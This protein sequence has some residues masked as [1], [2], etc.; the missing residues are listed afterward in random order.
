[1]TTSSEKRA[2]QQR[3]VRT[4][5]PYQ[6]ALW[7]NRDV[8]R[9]KTYMEGFEANGYRLLT[10][11]DKRALWRGES[12]AIDTEQA[13]AFKWMFDQI[14]RWAAGQVTPAEQAELAGEIPG[15]FGEDAIKDFIDPFGMLVPMEGEPF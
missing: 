7:R 9:F 12:I 10:D 3:T 8:D 5:E 4:G 15:I 13:W 2:A 1:M 14:E 6:T 11:D